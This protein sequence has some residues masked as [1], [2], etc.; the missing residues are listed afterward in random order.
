MDP[1]LFQRLWRR[2]WLSL[3]GLVLTGV[4]CFLLCFLSGYQRRQEEKLAQIEESFEILCVVSN[5]AGTRTYGLRL[6]AG[7]SYFVTAEE[8]E[9]HN[10]IQDLRMTKEFQASCAELAISDAMLMGVTNQ[11]CADA[12]EPAMGGGLAWIEESFYDSSEMLCLVSEEKYA[13]LDGEKTIQ[14]V[15]KDPYYVTGSWTNGGSGTVTFR[16]AG[17]YLGTGDAIFM[18]FPASQA[19]G[20]ALSGKTCV[21]SIAFLAADNRALPELSEAA[22]EQ[23]SQVNPMADSGVGSGAAL[24]IHD[25]QYRA[26]VAALEQNIQRTRYLLPLVALLGLGVGFLVSLLATRGE[27]RTYALMRT[28]GM[29]K[30]RLFF[31]ILR[32]QLLLP[33]AVILVLCALTK[34]FLPAFIFLLCHTAGC[35]VAVIRAIR[36]PPTVILR[37]QE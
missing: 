10:Y 2:P 17:C 32:E 21:D 7:M 16:V 6:P 31:S 18:P 27:S 9:I 33:L 5:K 26:T 34:A 36:V 11:R 28:L 4:L 37:E 13:L 1:Y 30:E 8:F 20:Y 22:L 14:L 19:L 23:F 12:L 15:V 29:K 25:E 24:T 35:F 3:C